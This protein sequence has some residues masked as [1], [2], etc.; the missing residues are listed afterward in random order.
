MNL[1][2]TSDPNLIKTVF[3]PVWT[4]VSRSGE[5]IFVVG[6]FKPMDILLI[7]NKKYIVVGPAPIPGE[8]EDK[9]L[10]VLENYMLDRSGSSLFARNLLLSCCNNITRDYLQKVKDFQPAVIKFRVLSKI[11]DSPRNAVYVITGGGDNDQWIIYALIKKKNTYCTPHLEVGA[12][13]IGYGW[14]RWFNSNILRF[15]LMYS[16]LLERGVYGLSKNIY[17]EKLSMHANLLNEVIT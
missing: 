8:A 6:N 7:E 11:Y 9:H 3:A 17:R 1:N 4:A 16:L 5:T 10:V 12:M 15:I 2:N 14:F 13:Y